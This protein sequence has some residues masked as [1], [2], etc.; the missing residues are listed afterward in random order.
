MNI[1][2]LGANQK[3]TTYVVEQLSQLHIE[4]VKLGH[5]LTFVYPA[6]DSRMIK[7]VYGSIS[8]LHLIM[9]P[10][11]LTDEKFPIIGQI[12]FLKKLFRS[13]QFDVINID[14][15][16]LLTALIAA[17]GTQTPIVVNLS[18][19]FQ[20]SWKTRF[21]LGFRKSSR[22]IVSSEDGRDYVMERG[23][24]DGQ[25]ID[26]VYDGFFE[27]RTLKVQNHTR[28]E[29]IRVP[30]G[31]FTIGVCSDTVSLRY[32]ES[33]ITAFEHVCATHSNTY[34]ILV[35]ITRADLKTR[36]IH[37]S[38]QQLQKIRFIDEQGRIDG[39]FSLFDLFFVLDCP[40]RGI[41]R[42]LIEVAGHGTPV[43]AFDSPANREIIS[44]MKSGFLVPINDLD[45]I[46]AVMSFAVQHPMEIK[47]MADKACALVTDKISCAVRTENLIQSYLRAT[48]EHKLYPSDSAH[49]TP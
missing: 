22:I 38:S 9:L 35:G 18:S 20:F 12:L 24:L 41:P 36:D 11:L 15:S 47:V 23:G 28:S 37:L 48:I 26:V 39:D 40:L 7:R 17:L 29:I 27:G 8:G 30:N 4:L 31:A 45:E 16:L 3:I 2:Y 34:L 44:H 25:S 1:L 46:Y 6:S 33:A 49:T 14:A 32:L 42:L 5:R 43:I 10:P 13:T 19:D 21:L